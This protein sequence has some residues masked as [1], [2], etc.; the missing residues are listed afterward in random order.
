[1]NVENT[2]RYA[3]MA[4][5]LI[6]T[7]RLTVLDQ[8]F[9]TIGNGYEWKNGELVERVN[10][11]EITPEDIPTAEEAVKLVVQDTL[12]DQDPAQWYS[13]WKRREKDP[14][15][16]LR[17]SF[18][19]YAEII[20][21]QI[22]LIYRIEERMQDMSVPDR[23]RYPY[24]F[25][26][27]KSVPS[28]FKTGLYP[29]S[30]YSDICNLP[31]NIKPDWLKEASR[32]YDFIIGHPELI[33]DCHKPDFNK[34]LPKVYERLKQLEGPKWLYRLEAISSDNGLWYNTANDYVWGCKDCKGEAKNLPMGYDHRYHLDD[35]N[36]F[37]SCS[38]KED[39]QH[40]Y[41]KEDAQWLLEHGFVFTRYL[42]CDYHEF[43]Q[44]TV[45][46]KETALKREVIDFMSLFE[47]GPDGKI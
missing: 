9:L 26:T 7:N 14:E 45:F 24:S 11:R 42:A 2:I 38:N 30:E 40:W 20:T 29:I 27:D 15:K 12:I 10:G 32:M 5:P 22:D 19:Y 46:L 17:D 43:P 18:K 41:S 3:L 4:W 37:S 13:V 6:E 39:L 28:R 33:P 34:W 47:G 31:D 21:G 36:W 8:M 44:E 35:K 25:I 1:M 16:I 23:K